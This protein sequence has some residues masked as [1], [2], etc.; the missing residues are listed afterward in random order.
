M[1]K[2]FPGFLT[3]LKHRLK[4]EFTFQEK[5]DRSVPH[6]SIIKEVVKN[7]LMVVSWPLHKLKIEIMIVLIYYCR[8]NGGWKIT[9]LWKTNFFRDKSNTF[10]I[11][12]RW[13][14]ILKKIKKIEFAL[15]PLFT[16]IGRV[17]HPFQKKLPVSTFHC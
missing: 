2:Q 5:V 11:L 13:V 17:E 8:W 6:L 1:P 4:I 15:P 7:P 14:S 3:T 10:W 9:K 12:H 16:Q